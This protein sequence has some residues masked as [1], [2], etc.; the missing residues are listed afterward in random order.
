MRKRSR[1]VETSARA[2][3]SSLFS[4]RSEI[5]LF[6]VPTIAPRIIAITVSSLLTLARFTFDRVY[7]IVYASART[8]RQWVNVRK[9][10]QVQNATACY[11]KDGRE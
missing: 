4:R 11:T 6:T 1:F 8:C 2:N 9:H 5:A 10:K 3:R 7:V